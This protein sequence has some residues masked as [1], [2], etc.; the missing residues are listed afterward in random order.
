MRHK[1]RNKRRQ[2]SIRKTIKH[3]APSGHYHIL[4]YTYARAR[5]LG[6]QIRP[7]DNP[8]YKLRVTTK[9][10]K[11]I[12]CGAAGY[13]DYPTYIKKYGLAF[14]NERRRLYKIRHNKD[15]HVH[16]TAGYYADTLLW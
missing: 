12:Y 15:R 16:G 1:T 10:G 6:V 9:S 3:H 4:P 13:N 11:T 5:K 14:A 7:S 2:L 8:K